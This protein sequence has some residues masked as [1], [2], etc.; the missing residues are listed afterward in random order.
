M[1]AA[2]S[3]VLGVAP[4]LVDGLVGAAADALDG[5]VGA[6]HL[7]VWHGLNVELLLSARG[8]GRRRRCSS[9]ASARVGPARSSAPRL[10]SA[11]DAY[12]AA[13]RGLN[14]VA[15]RVTAVAQPGSLPS[16]SA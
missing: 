15:N 11:D 12:V 5:A 16:T 7:A 6:V 14:A 8:P 4:A 1:L 2:V 9:S 3:V 13:L 10:P